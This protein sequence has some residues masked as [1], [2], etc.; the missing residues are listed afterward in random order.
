MSITER[1]QPP[2]DISTTATAEAFVRL[3]GHMGGVAINRMTSLEAVDSEGLIACVNDMQGVALTWQPTSA[4]YNVFEG[5]ALA[6]SQATISGI[7][8]I[9]LQQEP[10]TTFTAEK[11]AKAT[12]KFGQ[13]TYFGAGSLTGDTVDLISERYA[14]G[15]G[16]E[17]T[18]QLTGNFLV[19]DHA[20]VKQLKAE[21][22]NQL[23]IPKERLVN[24][25]SNFRQLTQWVAGCSIK[26]EAVDA[27]IIVMSK[28][29]PSAEVV[30]FPHAVERLAISAVRQADIVGSE[31]Q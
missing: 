27:A 2:L 20:R 26:G 31:A 14:T 9:S 29:N 19:F 17:Y 12:G 3:K 11:A 25:T 24:N 4:I 8:H 22:Q 30:V 7:K 6:V 5:N 18:A 23:K 1:I 28:Q 21:M 13:G 15:S 16:W 10:I